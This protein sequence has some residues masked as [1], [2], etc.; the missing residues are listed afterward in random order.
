MHLGFAAK[1]LYMRRVLTLIGADGATQCFVISEDGAE[2]ERKN[3]G[4]L[5]AVANYACVVSG[6]LLIEIFLGIVFG[7]DDCE[8]TGWVEEDLVA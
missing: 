3:S 2:A 4:K 8:I 5:E 1:A 7:D 6:G